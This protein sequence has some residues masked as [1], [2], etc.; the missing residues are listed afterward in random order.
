MIHYL[1]D[2][3]LGALG[4]VSLSVGASCINLSRILMRKIK[5]LALRTRKPGEVQTGRDVWVDSGPLI[6]KI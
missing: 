4:E 2:E 5:V 6:H 1:F 3:K